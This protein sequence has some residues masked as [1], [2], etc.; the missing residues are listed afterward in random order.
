VAKHA[1]ANRVI[2]ML[3]QDNSNIVMSVSDNGKGFNP[4]EKFKNKYGLLY[5]K[6]RAN[7]FKGR[8]N[9]VS[10][11]GKGATITVLLPLMDTS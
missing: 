2:L 10:Q 11:P 4:S 5:I 8:V 3:Y 6:E 1:S 9:V 7:R